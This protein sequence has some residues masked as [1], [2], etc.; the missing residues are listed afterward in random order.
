MELGIHSCGSYGSDVAAPPDFHPTNGNLGFV[1]D[2]TLDGWTI[3]TPPFM[4]DYFV[5]FNNGS[6]LNTKKIFKINFKI[7]LN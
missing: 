6:E 1:Y 2:Y 7:N 5:R 3:G 4:G